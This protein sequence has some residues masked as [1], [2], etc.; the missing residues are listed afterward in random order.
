MTVTITDPLLRLNREIDTDDL[1][2]GIRR[3][4]RSLSR[5]VGESD[6]VALAT[7]VE[8]RDEVEQGITDAIA[9]LRH[10][11]AAPASWTEIGDALGTTR[12]AAQQRYGHVGGG[13][14]PGGQPG[15]L[16]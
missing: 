10:D 4:V 15:N 16:R 5:R 3:Q 1:L 14:R 9:G 8:L 6:G 12:Q 7:L 2:A 11:P 13:R